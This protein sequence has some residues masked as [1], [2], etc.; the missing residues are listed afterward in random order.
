MACVSVHPLDVGENLPK[1]I[2]WMQKGSVHPKGFQK[3][4][5][6]T[7][8][9]LQDG[10]LLPDNV[11]ESLCA[12][13]YPVNES[14]GDNILLDSFDCLALSQLAHA[15]FPDEWFT[16]AN[17]GLDLRWELYNEFAFSFIDIGNEDPNEIL[18]I[19]L[20]EKL[21]RRTCVLMASRIDDQ[22]FGGRKGS[23]LRSCPLL[24]SQLFQRAF[25]QMTQWRAETEKRVQERDAKKIDLR[26]IVHTIAEGVLDVRNTCWECSKDATLKCTQCKIAIYCCKEC[27]YSHFRL[28]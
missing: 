14:S 19:T 9:G 4:L 20:Y 21:F 12:I 17:G 15:A 16:E 5:P 3:Y 24:D 25:L 13:L 26:G 2:L 8:A 27:T 7:T 10:T 18:S 6:H 28:M 11:A 1:A 23:F 22:V